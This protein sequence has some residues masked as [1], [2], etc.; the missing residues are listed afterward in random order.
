MAADFA[1]AFTLSSTVGIGG[2]VSLAKRLETTRAHS[3]TLVYLCSHGSYQTLSRFR[4]GGSDKPYP[5][6]SPRAQAN[7]CTWFFYTSLISRWTGR[8]VPRYSFGE[9]FRLAAE[10]TRGDTQGV[11][12]RS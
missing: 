1:A 9:S 10:P 6:R 7:G 4:L 5:P 12:P 11:E 2:L 3:F 8:G